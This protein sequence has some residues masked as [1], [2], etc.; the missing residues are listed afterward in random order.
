M[1]GDHASATGIS[2]ME[3]APSVNYPFD[4]G[5]SEGVKSTTTW[6]QV[7]G[8]W[9]RHTCLPPID[10]KRT[11][12]IEE[13]AASLSDNLAEEDIDPLNS[14]NA[15]QLQELMLKYQNN[16][17]RTATEVIKRRRLAFKDRSQ[18]DGSRKEMYEILR[19]NG[20]IH[21]NVV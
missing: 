9:Q 18:N 3:I 8:R 20:H 14:Y 17:K 4:N 10:D 1:Q 7:D 5:N 6:R 15:D 11:K 21:T 19:N 12:N 13:L 2:K 16:M